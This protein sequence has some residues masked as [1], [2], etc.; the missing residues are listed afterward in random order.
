MKSLRHLQLS[1]ALAAI[2]A[3]A[4]CSATQNLSP[5]T[6]A[7]SDSRVATKFTASYS[8]TI[9]VN[10]DCSITKTFTYKGTGRSKFL[11]SSSELIS[12]TWNCGSQDVAGSATLT[13]TKHPRSSITASLSG[14]HVKNPCDMPPLSFTI[15]SGTGRLRKAT[16]S[17]TLVFT[18]LSSYC[19]YNQYTDKWR[20]TLKP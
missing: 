12:L 20:G 10:G 11:G 8:G 13:S 7:G 17:G 16:G 5:S 4:A 14:T 2:V 1:S 15:T 9:S 6:A 19:L 3:L 18:E